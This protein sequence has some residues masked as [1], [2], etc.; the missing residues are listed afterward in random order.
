MGKKSATKDDFDGLV[1]DTT[2]AR[3]QRIIDRFLKM[4]IIGVIMDLM[5]GGDADSSEN[6]GSDRKK[7]PASGS[8]KSKKSSDDD[9]G[10]E[11]GSMKKKMDN[12]WGPLIGLVC[13]GAIMY[14]KAM[15]DN[16]AGVKFS[17]AANYYDVMD[18]PRQS[19]MIDVRKKYKSLALT[20]HPDKNPDCK[21][22]PE[23][24]AAISKAYETLS[25]VD[26][27]K[28]YDAKGGTSESLNSAA[29][30]SLTAENFES[31]VLRS[32]DVWIVEVY[33][34]NDRAS[35]SYHP[36]W[37][38]TATALQKTAKFGRIDAIKNPDA[39][40][41]FPTRI[42]VFPVVYRF[43]RG[44]VVDSWQV[45]GG[46]EHS[47]NSLLSQW[48]M[49]VYPQ[50]PIIEGAAAVT[51]WWK[52]VDRPRLLIC[53][54]GAVIR[55][56]PK[57]NK[58]GAVLK[59]VHLWS[60]IFSVGLADGKDCT[61][62]LKAFN[63]EMPEPDN[64]KG[65]PWSLI[66]VPVGET[67]TKGEIF[68]T[69][70]LSE[71]PEEME[72]VIQSHITVEAPH[73]TARNHKQLC[74]AGAASRTFCLLLVDMSNEQVAKALKEVATSAVDYAKELAENR[75]AEGVEEG[76]TPNVDEAFR[77]QA[78]QVTTSTSRFPGQPVAPG[79]EFFT[80]WAEV[81]HAPMFL[82]ELDTQRVAAV[83]PSILGQV[84]QQI[85]YEDLKLKELPEDFNLPG[86]MPDP[87]VP[88][89]RVA[90]AT[91]TAPIGALFTFVFVAAV[92]A[93]APEL[94]VPMLGA[95]AAGMMAV[96]IVVWP[97][98]MRRTL[99]LVVGGA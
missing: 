71:F 47:G 3:N 1:E 93:V 73:L 39:L 16:Y 76:S 83:K 89:M 62:A 60:D 75:E 44:E 78:V 11:M 80:A 61:E 82:V 81:G 30:E 27:K 79:S 64:K 94:E 40:N 5:K 49:E 96:V 38:E 21:E 46:D 42:K 84:S 92:A 95:G 12:M 77:I 31:K 70:D 23:K 33:D 22:C 85:A 4:L 2:K 67:K 29:S 57:N 37:E 55:R 91:L 15:E 74:A 72:K 36:V 41:F 97:L 13:V 86:I 56:G 9:D 66:F 19:E 69:D 14:G 8:K 51:S 88:L 17:D 18:M 20:W 32:N 68:S 90:L 26:K 43:A 7:A 65:H 87:E 99:A 53:G 98:A 48:I 10:F 58:F 28:A 35:S 6:A 24:F 50:F 45:T 54:G 52:Q 25:D 34:P 59:Q 63:V